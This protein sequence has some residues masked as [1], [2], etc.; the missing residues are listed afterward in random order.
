MDIYPTDI[1]ET[2]ISPN[3]YFPQS[4]NFPKDI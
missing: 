1:L 2:D 4:D 3:G